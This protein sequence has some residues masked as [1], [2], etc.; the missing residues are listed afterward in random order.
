MDFPFEMIGAVPSHLNLSAYMTAE[1]TM[2]G[3][4]QPSLIGILKEWLVRTAYLDER[5]SPV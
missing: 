4:L 3:V 5:Y 1:P 2:L